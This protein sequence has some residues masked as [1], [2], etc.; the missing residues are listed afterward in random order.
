M[1]YN[2]V[3]RQSRVRYKYAVAMAETATPF[4]KNVDIVTNFDADL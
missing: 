4:S 1:I 3:S 2:F